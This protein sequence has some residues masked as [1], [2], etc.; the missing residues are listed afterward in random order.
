MTFPFAE[1]EAYHQRAFKPIGATG[2]GNNEDQIVLMHLER[3]QM[4]VLDSSAGGP[5]RPLA[6][7][8]FLVQ[9]MDK[10]GPLP[11]VPALAEYPNRTP[12]LGSWDEWKKGAL[13]DPFLSWKAEW[14]SMPKA[15]KEYAEEH[16]V[17]AMLA[18]RDRQQAE[19]APSASRR[20]G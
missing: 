9:Y 5:D 8:S 7:W 1:T 16:G 6:I 13:R 10:D 17:D 3:K 18:Y 12:G 19:K 20:T 14:N 2:A 15:L 11:D 4:C